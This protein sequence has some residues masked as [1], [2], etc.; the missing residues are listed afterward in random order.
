[1]GMQKSLADRVVEILRENPDVRL[2]PLDLARRYIEKFSDTAEEILGRSNEDLTKERLIEKRI[3]RYHER[4]IE[5]GEEKIKIEVSRPRK[6]YY[7]EEDD[8]QEIEKEGDTVAPSSTSKKS[9]EQSYVPFMQFLQDEMGLYCKRIDDKK[10][11]KRDIGVNKWLHPD[12]VGLEYLSGD[13]HEKV[14]KMGGQ[15]S[16]QR[17]RLWSFE[18]KTEVKRR[19]VRDAFFQA[20]ANSSWAHYGYLVG[21]F[22]EEVLSDL[23]ILSSLHGIGVIQY[24]I[25]DKD[26]EEESNRL[27][28]PARERSHLD[29][30]SINSLALLENRD[31]L[32]FM[33][34]V[35]ALDGSELIL[36][37]SAAW[38]HEIKKK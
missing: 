30:G 7:T 13:W 32:D 26:S 34:N 16:A 38:D 31:F 14:K 33:E 27:V 23:K 36:K 28:I 37:N 20:V 22:D 1:M 10:S 5:L 35:I 18:V 24:N 2:T 12:I 6:Y 17:C 29:W 15:F 19:D 8:E 25:D 21:I 3:Y 9:E 11:K 4:I